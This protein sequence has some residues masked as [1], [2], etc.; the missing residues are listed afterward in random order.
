LINT[1]W[2]KWI[3]SGLL[4]TVPVLPTMAQT[5][6]SSLTQLFPALVG[7]QLS[8]E[9]LTQLQSLSQQTL[10]QLRTVLTPE[11]QLQFNNA[12]SQGTSVRAAVESLNLSATQRFQ[13]MGIL[14]T[15][16]SQLATILTPSQWQQ[17]Q[18]NAKKQ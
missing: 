11:Q 6:T 17:I 12:L 16:R 3:V 10:P 15:K 9:Q 13:V 4:V 2:M 14:K 7:V 18:Q 5:H 8:P 1:R